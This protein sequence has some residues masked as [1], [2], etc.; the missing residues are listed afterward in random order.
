M[1]K[2]DWKIAFKKAFAEAKVLGESADKALLAASQR[3][4]EA[5][6][7][8]LLSKEELERAQA[9]THKFRTASAT[10]RASKEKAEGKKKTADD[11]AVLAVDRAKQDVADAQVRQAEAQRRRAEAIANARH[12]YNVARRRLVPMLKQAG[13]AANRD[14]LAK[15]YKELEKQYQAADDKFDIEVL[16]DTLD[17][18]ETEL[19]KA[20]G[21]QQAPLLLAQCHQRFET[22]RATTALAHAHP[23]RK[24]VQELLKAL[25]KGSL[26]GG[27]GHPAQAMVTLTQQVEPALGAI[28][29][30]LEALAA[31]EAEVR[32][33]LAA[34]ALHPFR[35]QAQVTLIEE[36]LR[37]LNHTLGSSGLATSRE[38]LEQRLPELERAQR[39]AL[40]Q[41]QSARGLAAAL[42]DLERQANEF[43]KAWPGS[44]QAC[45]HK[46]RLA[47][48]VPAR[49]ELGREEGQRNYISARML[50]D[51]GLDV[52]QVLA[53][54][55]KARAE[56][57]LA[58]QAEEALQKALAAA[59]LK[60]QQDTLKAEK[61]AR[62]VL[63]ASSLGAIGK[64]SFGPWLAQLQRL[65]TEATPA[66]VTITAAP[67]QRL[68]RFPGVVYTVEVVCR[69]KDSQG[70]DVDQFVVH[71]HPELRKSELGTNGSRF[72]AKPGRSIAQ[73]AGMD[74]S[75][76]W[77]IA[78]AG[79]PRFSAV[80]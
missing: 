10:V 31:V 11:E 12:D 67:A 75:S 5:E 68:T 8:R 23:D 42:D 2:D 61:A 62:E 50:L 27:Q 65:A 25:P 30:D 58:A 13:A 56:G 51:E 24:H 4:Q 72:H 1:G 19:L 7:A 17:E 64:S 43:D 15:L 52:L 46:V 38:W 59:K 63:H 41:E 6:A 69:V 55:A 18:V 20:V 28:E 34:L 78:S 70:A 71:Y 16:Y 76:H 44:K 21:P 80:D 39:E 33:Q 37:K 14:P 45:N 9:D 47:C 48:L 77:L 40:Q 79:V 74:E 3:Q 49:V 32:K 53:A 60:Q 54:N 36:A 73:H 22:L 26:D 57:L 35:L 29:A 66:A